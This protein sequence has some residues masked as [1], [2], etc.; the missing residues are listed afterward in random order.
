MTHIRIKVLT[1]LLMQLS[2]IKIGDHICTLGL[3]LP[4]HMP[5]C[6]YNLIYRLLLQY[7]PVYLSGITTVAIR[8]KLIDNKIYLVYTIENWQQNEII[9]N[10][11]CRAWLENLLVASTKLGIKKEIDNCLKSEWPSFKVKC[12][13]NEKR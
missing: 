2:N 7:F 13:P 10:N 6:S 4:N 5:S 1:G 9:W 8:H 12:F 3:Y 11:I